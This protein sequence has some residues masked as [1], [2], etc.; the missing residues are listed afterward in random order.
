MEDSVSRMNIALA[1][2]AV[3]SVA[4]I[5]PSAASAQAPAAFTETA[6]AA[7]AASSD[8][9]EWTV[10]LG[11]T[12]NMGN[13]RSF[14]L[15]GG[16]HFL[17]RRD[18]HLFQMDLAFTYGLA[19]IRDTNGVWGGFNA[20]AQNVTGKLR[21]DLFFDPD[22]SF[23]VVAGG[24]NDPF[25]GLDFRFQG[26]L[27]ISRSLLREAEGAH[28]LWVELGADI[29]YDD[30]S[31]NPACPAGLSPVAGST[32]RLRCQNTTTPLPT[33]V[34]ILP[35]SRQH[36]AGR[37]FLGYDNHMNSTW[38]YQTGVEGIVGAL[39][40]STFDD[41]GNATTV[42]NARVNW[43]NELGLSLV[44]GLAVSLRFNLFYELVPAA[45]RDNIDT[46]TILSLQYTLM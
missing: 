28:R 9:T 32:D 34:S 23:F 44:D 40:G 11:G 18:V 15:A 46:Q 43:T 6:A 14:Q 5:A 16:T 30:V 13:T 7:P 31:P 38:R 37:L 27:G 26:Q 24:R 3:A 4:A 10:Q 29:T 12:L 22:W 1:A 8:D 21:Y 17:V 19:A 39:S 25:A 41:V 2:L 33:P 45:G 35:G 20:T 36:Y 42:A